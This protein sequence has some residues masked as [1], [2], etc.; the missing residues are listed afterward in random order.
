MEQ[1]GEAVEG[2]LSFERD[3]ATDISDNSMSSNSNL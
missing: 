2:L 1:I 3:E